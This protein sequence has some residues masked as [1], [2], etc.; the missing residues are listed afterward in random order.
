MNSYKMSLI[1]RLNYKVVN[2]KNNLIFLTKVN[3]KDL[4][5]DTCG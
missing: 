2:S 1:D 3:R 5:I 4:S